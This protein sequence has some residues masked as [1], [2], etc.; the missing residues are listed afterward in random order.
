[1]YICWM[2]TFKFEGDFIILKHI[3]KNEIRILK[4][5]FPYFPF[6]IFSFPQNTFLHLHQHTSKIQT[7]PQR[8]LP[9]CIG[10]FCV[11]LNA[12]VCCVSPP[13][14]QPLLC[15]VFPELILSFYNPLNIYIWPPRIFTMY[16]NCWHNRASRN[17]DGGLMEINMEISVTF[18]FTS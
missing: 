10:S 17:N 8:K 2:M 4:S 11:L 1:M 9:A 16:T 3:C 6:P 13:L 18:I 15:C 7:L 5:I 12:F 14:K